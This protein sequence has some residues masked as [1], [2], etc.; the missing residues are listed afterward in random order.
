MS[1][2]SSSEKTPVEA[3]VVGEAGVG[4]AASE[5]A[6]LG[7]QQEL[8][9]NRGWLTILSQ[10][11]VISSVS[12]TIITFSDLHHYPDCNLRSH[13]ALEDLFL[14][15]S[16]AVANSHSS[17]AGS[18]SLSLPNASPS[19]SQNSTLDFPL[20]LVPTTGP[21]SSVHRVPAFPYPS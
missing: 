4:S 6:V 5:L 3:R 17:S 21:T 20:P 11:L 1:E 16:T 12:P 9:R 14:R 7:Y 18:S 2:L 19:P 8:K 10:S 15:P 13:T